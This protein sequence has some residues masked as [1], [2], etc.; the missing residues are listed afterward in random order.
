[1][2]MLLLLSEKKKYYESHRFIVACTCI[3]NDARFQILF[4]KA[5]QVCSL[6]RPPVYLVIK[7]E[8]SR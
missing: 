4:R 1:M 6:N 5:G 2:Q 7:K 8:A 3:Q